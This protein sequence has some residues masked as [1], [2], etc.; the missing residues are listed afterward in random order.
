MEAV[1]SLGMMTG[2][3]VGQQRT[4]C[5]NLGRARDYSFSPQHPDRLCYTFSLSS[6]WNGAVSP[7]VKRPEKEAAHSTPPGEE[8]KNAWGYN[9]PYSRTVFMTRCL[10]K[11]KDI[12]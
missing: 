3:R 4:P 2:L 1:I 8:N 6:N 9:T 12:L 11:H 7:G 10:I 5:S